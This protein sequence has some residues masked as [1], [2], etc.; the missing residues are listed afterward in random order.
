MQEKTPINCTD[1]WS[2]FF[3]EKIDRKWVS[4]FLGWRNVRNAGP[5]TDEQNDQSVYIPK[6]F[7]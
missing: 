2:G 3:K 7:K 6:I 4:L 1:V 5:M